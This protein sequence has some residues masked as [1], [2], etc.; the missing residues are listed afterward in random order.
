M[1]FFPPKYVADISGRFV[2]P[3]SRNVTCY[4]YRVKVSKAVVKIL[5]SD[6]HKSW[7]ILKI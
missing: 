6:V 3:N 2:T 5:L 1:F 4:P 7:V